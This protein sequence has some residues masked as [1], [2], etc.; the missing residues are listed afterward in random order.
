MAPERDEDPVTWHDVVEILKEIR[1]LDARIGRLETGH[2][3]VVRKM[4]EMS[5]EVHS[6]RWWVVSA[7]VGGTLLTLVLRLLL[8]I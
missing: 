2:E 7:V 4:E 3:W 5:R 8:G 6:L 1:Q